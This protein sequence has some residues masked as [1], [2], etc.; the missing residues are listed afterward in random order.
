[1]PEMAIANRKQL[2]FLAYNQANLDVSVIIYN[3]TSAATAYFEL[4]ICPMIFFSIL[5]CVLFNW[6][7]V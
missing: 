7:L 3:R 6:E 4:S 2:Y 5:S 1:M